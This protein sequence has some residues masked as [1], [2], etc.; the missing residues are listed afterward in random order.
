MKCVLLAFAVLTISTSL[1]STCPPEDAA[2]DPSVVM[3]TAAG[4]RFQ[5]ER[6][7]TPH[8]VRGACAW[9]HLAEL[10]AAGGNSLRTWGSRDD[11]KLYDEADALGLS[12][13]AGLWFDWVPNRPE[14]M[15]RQ[16]QDLCSRVRQYKD[17]PA[18][19]VWGLGN[20]YEVG[21][22]DPALWKAIEELAA[23]IKQIDPN[24]PVITVV[25]DVTQDKVAA[26]MQHCP[27]MDALGVNS[28]GGLSSL[29][30][31]LRAYGWDK[32]YLVT[33][34]GEFGPQDLG[35]T[36]WDAPIQLDSTYAAEHWIG[37]GL[38]LI[39]EEM[40][41]GRCLG[42]YL[43]L[44]G[45]HRQFV[46]TATWYHLF[47][48][49]GERLGG[50]DAAVRA[51]TGAAPANRAPEII[52]FHSSAA[53][54]EVPSGSRHCAEIRCREPDGDPLLIR[55]EILGER[56]PDSE[57]WPTSYPLCI[58]E[59]EDGE[60]TFTAPEEKGAYRLY[61]YVLDGKGGA[62]TANAPFLVR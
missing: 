59:K 12:V 48:H 4:H 61:A 16:F 11:P 39:A 50:G 28:Y 54:K 44:W 41:A 29:P 24:H 3:I 38:E 40:D 7:G 8:L 15:R 34:F 23:A 26:L 58:V 9:D 20:E 14:Y 45:V 27:S 21:V 37:P 19:L 52:L 2:R 57:S 53:L 30:A 6:N 49:S 33:E 36:A 22:S 17:H 13:C 56:P 35:K 43:Y 60:L 47:L 1:S 5:L 10:K 31:R 25:A 46:A 51:W 18:I 62:A 32:P 55:W 42:S